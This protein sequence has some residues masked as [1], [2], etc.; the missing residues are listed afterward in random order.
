[1]FLLQFRFFSFFKMVLIIPLITWPVLCFNHGP[2]HGGQIYEGF[3]CIRF[4]LIAQQ[5]STLTLS[6][7]LDHISILCQGLSQG[8]SQYFRQLVSYVVACC[9]A[10]INFWFIFRN[11]IILWSLHWL[12]TQKLYPP[13]SS[14]QMGNGW[15]VH[16]SW[17]EN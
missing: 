10:C 12:A 13:S 8:W 7:Y 5:W 15:L 1:M 16:V 17:K 11:P 2:V 9:E 3:Y 14:A 4:F 6:L